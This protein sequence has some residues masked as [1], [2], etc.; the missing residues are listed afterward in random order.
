MAILDND[1]ARPVHLDVLVSEITQF[2]SDVWPN[3]DTSP[4]T[5]HGQLIGSFALKLAR[6]SELTVSVA[7]GNSPL[8][9][10]GTQLDNLLELLGFTREEGESDTSYFSRY[11]REIAALS[12]STL[13]A[14]QSLLYRVHGV[15]KVTLRD[16]RGTTSVTFRDLEISAG[17]IHCAV[18][19]GD[20]Y[21]VAKV[22]AESVP[23][24]PHFL[25]G[26]AAY[27][28]GTDI[29][30]IATLKAAAAGAYFSR[31]LVLQ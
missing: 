20:D 14:L 19:G 15:T 26:P 6:I 31:E 13:E 24:G 9:A 17:G 8:S 27:I 5:P 2:F 25:G 29:A 11:V 16:N 10:K 30:N 4:E 21:S 18:V 28:V 12:G 1:G 23:P 7:E 22:I 3:I